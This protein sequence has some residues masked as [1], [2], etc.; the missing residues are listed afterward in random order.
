[1]RFV[2]Q[3]VRSASVSVDHK[4]VGSID[5]GLLVFIGVCQEESGRVRRTPRK[6]YMNM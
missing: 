1:M 5:K 2:I 3:R 6:H 4:V